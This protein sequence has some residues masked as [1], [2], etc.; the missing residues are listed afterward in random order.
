MRVV[1]ITQDEPQFLAPSM[2]RL[3]SDLP[4]AVEVVGCAVLEPSPTGKRMSLAERAMELLKVFGPAFFLRYGVRHVLGRLRPSQGI[5]PVL[6]RHGVPEL[7]IDGSINSKT[8]LTQ[9]AQLRPD[10]LVS[11]AGNQIFKKR[12]IELAPKGCLNLHT[13]LLPKYRGLMPT[14]WVLRHGE[15]ETGA[16]VFFVDE[17]I[18][19]GPILVQKRIPITT[20]CLE[21]LIRKSKEVGMQAVREAIEL[22]HKGQY[23]LTPN[24]D[25]ES[26]YFGFPTRADV[27][28]FKAAGKRLF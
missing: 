17:G 4:A 6:A 23:D 12:L 9:M 18:D 2:D 24:P 3:L 7:R 20:T 19:S 5:S 13:S 21:E 27:Q 28:A 8:S 16:S 11:V 25:E 26:S 22:V 15:R 14:F 1:F 10:L